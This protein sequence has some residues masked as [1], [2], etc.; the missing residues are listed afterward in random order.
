MRHTTTKI[1]TWTG[2]NGYGENRETV[3]DP[4]PQIGGIKFR[5]ANID[6]DQITVD[7]LLDGSPIVPSMTGT[8]L[9][10]MREHL[11]RPVQANVFRV[12]FEDLES[13]TAEGRFA[14]LFRTEEGDNI[15]LRVSVGAIT[16]QQTADGVTPSFTG[17]IRTYPAALDADGNPLLKRDRLMKFKRIGIPTGQVGDNE[18]DQYKRGPRW[19]RLWLMSANVTNFKVERSSVER[20]NKLLADNNEDLE[21][22]GRAPVAGMY[23]FDPV[24]TGYGLADLFQTAGKNLKLTITTDA[25]G[26][27]N[28][29][30]EE[31]DFYKGQVPV[32]L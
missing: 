21:A 18:Y 17:S 30:A 32:I 7:L 28:A 20:F 22:D 2:Q 8:E 3:I 29:I 16:A 15:V 24:S 27:T 23:V 26:V 12:D 11:G 6:A 5:T 14:G 4:G 31:I 19:R 9:N 10:A 25:A 13:K 1:Q